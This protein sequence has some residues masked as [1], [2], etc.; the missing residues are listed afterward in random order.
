[1][2]ISIVPQRKDIVNVTFPKCRFYGDALANNLCLNVGHI[3]VCKSKGH[4]CARGSTVDLEVVPSIELEI[5]FV[6]N[7]C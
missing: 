6:E 1:M 3:N 4:F 2:Y 5:I 7:E